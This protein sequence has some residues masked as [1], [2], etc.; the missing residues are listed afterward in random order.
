MLKRTERARFFEQ[1]QSTKTKGQPRATARGRPLNLLK[2]RG[3]FCLEK[4][5]S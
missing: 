3:D 2:L 1:Q 5:K 4:S